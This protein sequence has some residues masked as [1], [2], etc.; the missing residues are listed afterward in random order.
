L[1]PTLGYNGKI[2]FGGL[3]YYS[4]SGVI[5]C[6]KTD[7]SHQWSYYPPGNEL[8]FSTPAVCDGKVYFSTI[9]MY[10]YFSGK[11]YCLDLNT[12]NFLWS[13]AIGTF[14]IFS[15]SPSCRDVKVYYI[16]TDLYSYGSY[17][18]CFDANSGALIWQ[19]YLGLSLGF[20][21]SQAVTK[22]SVYAVALDIYSY[23]NVLY[24]L[25]TNGLLEWQ[26]T[27]PGGYG[28]L[29]SGSTP[30]CSAD[31][32]FVSPMD[33]YTYGSTLY[34]YDQANGNL[35]WS[36]ILSAPSLVYPSIAEERVYT[37]DFYGNIYAFEDA[38]KISRISGGLMSVKATIR[39][40]GTTDLSNLDCEIDVTGGMMSG[41]SKHEVENIP[42]LQAGKAKTIRVMPIM[43]IG[44][45][46]IDVKVKMAGST[47]TKSARGLVLGMLVIV[48]P[49]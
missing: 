29:F 36:Y 23:S 48:L 21:L 41:I 30:S 24:K 45:I 34:C 44:M 31:K 38:L 19:F 7:G 13:Q 49:G 42:T 37:A 5:E 33:Y 47:I 2:I 25:T 28:Y 18:K 27:I 20:G 35:L 8:V 17:L 1:T 46:D 40:K 4:F 10:S 9:D 39:N 32:V 12:G 22:N 15:A 6:Y 14:F 26:V 43:G 11:L 3:E 16:D